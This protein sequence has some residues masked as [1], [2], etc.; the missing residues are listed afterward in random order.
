MSE[1]REIQDNG[2]IPLQREDARRIEVSNEVTET[3]DESVVNDQQEREKTEPSKSIPL[4]L[5]VQGPDGLLFLGTETLKD[6]KPEGG[7]ENSLELDANGEPVTFN[8][9][10]LFSFCCFSFLNAK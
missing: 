3:N 9:G 7:N 6:K 5:L 8:F 4:S 2:V 10:L 1:L